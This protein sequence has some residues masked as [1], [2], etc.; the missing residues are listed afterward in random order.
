MRNFCKISPKLHQFGVNTVNKYFNDKQND[1]S[2]KCHCIVK[3]AFTL[4]LPV[5]QVLLIIND[6]TT[7]ET[8][9]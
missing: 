1:M 9:I 4:V 6:I 2:M 8:Q 3:S 5:L 7:T